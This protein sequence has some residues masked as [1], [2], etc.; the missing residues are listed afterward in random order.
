MLDRHYQ[1]E[2]N[3]E[4]FRSQ[5]VYKFW[6]QDLKTEEFLSLTEILTRDQHHHRHHQDGRL[7]FGLD[8]EL[9]IDLPQMPCIVITKISSVCSWLCQT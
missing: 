4:G 1:R 3:G 7:R 2:E 9:P 8:G 6:H 5:L